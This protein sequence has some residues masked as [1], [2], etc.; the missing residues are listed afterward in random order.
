M[1]PHAAMCHK[2]TAIRFVGVLLHYYFLERV[3]QTDRQ[4]N[5]R[6][7]S[8]KRSKMITCD[9]LV[10]TVGPFCRSICINVCSCFFP[11]VGTRSIS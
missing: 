11:C 5:T 3:R 6:A 2:K 10:V 7:P 1:A 9:G 4:T 8:G